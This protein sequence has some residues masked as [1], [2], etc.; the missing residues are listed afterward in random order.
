MT[1]TPSSSQTT[2]LGEWRPPPSV[3]IFQ[4]RN[5]VELGG[6]HLRAPAVVS[7]TDMLADVRS[8]EPKALDA[9]LADMMLRS[10]S[11]SDLA[12]SA[13]TPTLIKAGPPELNDVHVG[14]DGHDPQPTHP[15]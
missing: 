2:V 1:G 12:R 15:T 14:L 11:E 7:A 10:G 8:R 13:V 5:S 3:A 6:T 9:T 4:F